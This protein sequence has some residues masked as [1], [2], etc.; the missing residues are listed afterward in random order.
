MKR[1][2]IWAVIA[3]SLVLCVILLNRT[4][5]QPVISAPGTF[6]H[7]PGR[8]QV[9]SCSL[10]ESGAEPYLVDTSTGRVF[11]EYN[12]KTNKERYWAEEKVEG[13]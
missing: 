4:L 7:Q 9:F 11:L 13:R 6:L 8:W 2:V 5:A 12:R 3:V 1:Y 10:G